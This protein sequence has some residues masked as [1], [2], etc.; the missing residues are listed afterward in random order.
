MLIN[1]E[2]HCAP[3]WR[4]GRNGKGCSV[5]FFDQKLIK[6]ILNMM[7]TLIQN[8]IGRRLFGVVQDGFGVCSNGGN[9]SIYEQYMKQHRFAGHLQ[10]ER[11]R[12]RND[13]TCVRQA[14][15]AQPS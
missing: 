8:G 3:F 12:D 14:F 5:R 7:D 15:P 1:L 10:F 6:Q 9:L 11:P 2:Q 4:I 13:V